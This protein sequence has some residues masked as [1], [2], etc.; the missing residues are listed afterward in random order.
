MGK[1]VGTLDLTDDQVR[2]VQ[3]G[4][5][6]DEEGAQFPLPAQHA[7]VTLFCLPTRWSIAVLVGLL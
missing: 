2:A 4:V 6:K 7:A 1:R 5:E 3:G